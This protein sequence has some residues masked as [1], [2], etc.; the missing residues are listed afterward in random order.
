MFQ[1]LQDYINSNKA[2]D[3]KRK[4]KFLDFEIYKYVVKSDERKA[5]IED[6][7]DDNGNYVDKLS[8]VI[9]TLDGLVYL[10]KISSLM[11]LKSIDVTT[12]PYIILHTLAYN[13]YLA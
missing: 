3:E 8:N 7:I 13:D 2:S 11:I 9:L 10:D 5:L 12:K 6:L 1:T 4:E